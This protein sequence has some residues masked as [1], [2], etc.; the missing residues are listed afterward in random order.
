MAI[1][2]P[3]Q[4]Q[5]FHHS[6]GERLVFRALHQLPDSYV[7]FYSYRWLGTVSQRRSE[8][9]ADFVVLHPSKGILSIEVKAGDIGYR[10][11]EWIQ[12]NRHTGEEKVI[13][14][15][16]QAAESQHRISDFLRQKGIAKQPLVGR[17]AWFTS[18]AFSNRVPLPIEAVPDIILDEGSLEHPGEAL[19]RAFAYW[20]DTLHFTRVPELSPSEFHQVVELLMPTFHLT[21]TISSTNLSVETSFIQLTRQQAAILDFLAEQ[22]TAAIQGP[23]GTG[24]TVLAVEKTRRL[25]SAGRKVLYI[26]FNEFL[27]AHIR[28][29]NQNVHASFHN[30][31]SL[32]EELM[33]KKLASPEEQVQVFEDWF[34]QDFNDD[35]WP[36]EDVVIDEGQDFTADMLEH[37]SFLAELCDGSF[38]VF[39]DKNQKVIRREKKD[40]IHDNAECR[41][42][43]YRDVRNT[44]EIASSMASAIG[45]KRKDHYINEIQGIPVK[46][47]FYRNSSELRSICDNFVKK[48]RGNHIRLEDMVILSVH[49]LPHSGLKG[50]EKLCGVPVSY[51][52][53]PGALWLTNV[54]RFKGLEAKAVLLIDVELSHLAEPL[55]RRLVYTGGSRANTYLK[56]AFN[57]DIPKDGYGE[58][59]QN[60]GSEGHTRKELVNFLDMETE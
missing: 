49:S 6:E 35:D 43:L 17:A 5:D 42:V 47:G 54:Y 31:R 29:E 20:R 22:R 2:Y 52:P 27:L 13:D 44:E 30:V 59:L 53:K 8:G 23:A 24:K 4:V 1:F 37:L 18:V 55:M 45:M 12:T 16:G 50:V 10:G 34:K 39:Y 25:A 57:E 21:R 32:A 51:T 56:V 46:A 3:S 14:P 19:D 11:G 15:L 26:C 33:G 36:Y 9:E 28:H 38:Y 58:L 41:L 60:M 7:V 40:W 48:M